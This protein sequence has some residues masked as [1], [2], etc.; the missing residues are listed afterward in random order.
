MCDSAGGMKILLT[1][2]DQLSAQVGADA[3]EGN[4]CKL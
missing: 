1:F 4:F 3:V 2:G